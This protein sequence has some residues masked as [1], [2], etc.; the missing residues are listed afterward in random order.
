MPD[1]NNLL[2]LI[3]DFVN[4]LLVFIAYLLNSSAISTLLSAAGL[5]IGLYT[6]VKVKKVA[7]IQQNERRITQELLDVD[8]IEGDLTRV[9]N[10]LFEL[11]DKDNE[12]EFLAKDLAHRLGAIRGIRKVLNTSNPQAIHFGTI[13]LETGFFCSNHI[14]KVIEKSVSR[15]DIM[16]GSTR[17]IS[18]YFTLDKL[19]QACERGVHVRIVGIDPNSPDDILLDATKT[20]S[21]PAPTTADQYRKLVLDTLSNIKGTIKEWE[22]TKARSLFE[23]KV[24]ASVPRISMAISDSNINLGFLQLFR[25]AQPKKLE[26]RHYLSIK[27]S[28]PL[29]DVVTRHFEICWKQA[30][31]I[32]NDTI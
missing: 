13:L 7:L 1:Q 3:S 26:D 9:I 23:Y 30:Q 17:I 10:K 4:K 24:L 5:V 25:D 12:A 6:L 29:G 2:Q 28:T 14:E 27:C 21:N 32:F 20:V 22:D 11:R 15:L 8:Q 19:R 31:S 18:D 16:T